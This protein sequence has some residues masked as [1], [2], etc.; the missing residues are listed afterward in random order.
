MPYVADRVRE[1]G[2]VTGTGN[3]TLSGAPTGGFQTFNTAFG[4]NTLFL[5]CIVDTANSKWETGRGY[6]SGSTTLVRS[7]VLASD[8]GSGVQT[9]FGSA[10][11]VDVFCTAAAELVDNA[12]IGHQIAVSR[13][14]A[15]P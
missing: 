6:L 11:S 3:V 12:N 15:M 8:S 9:T 4:L 14:L 10:V 13:G 5:Y 7:N 2:T 1:N